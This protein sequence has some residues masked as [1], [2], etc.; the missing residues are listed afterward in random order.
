MNNK[1]NT[2]KIIVFSLL[3]IALMVETIDAL[4][5][6]VRFLRRA[7]VIFLP[8]IIAYILSL[9]VNPMADGLQKRFHLPRGVCAILVMVLTVGFAGGIIAA[10]IWKIVDEIRSIYDNFPVIYQN[11]R[12]TWLTISDNLSNIRALLPEN[13]QSVI[14]SFYEQAMQWVADFAKNAQIVESAGNVAKKLPSIFITSIVFLIALY[15]MVADSDT[16]SLAVKKPLSKRFVDRVSKLKFEIKHYVGGYVKAQL[17]I[18]CITFLI[19]LI[20]LNI[21]NIEYALLI[22]LATA[23]VDALPF[24]G[25]GTVLLPWSVINFISGKPKLGIGLLIIYFS[26]MLMRQMIEPK[27]IGKNVGMH[28][29]LTLL[30]MYVGYRVLSIGGMILG[31]LILMFAISLYKVGLFDDIIEFFKRLFL[32]INREIQDIKASLNNKGD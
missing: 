6:V 12:N 30:S 15:F 22:A 20:G 17:T 1:K 13:I 18:M 21:L 19:L 23:F 9:L 8:F 31:P 24:F 25:S 4:P 26:V 3:G 5:L 27:L 28:P 32:K 7:L 10:I 14:D 16:V 2:L 29:L 11:I